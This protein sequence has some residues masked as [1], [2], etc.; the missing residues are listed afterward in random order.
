MTLP[1]FHVQQLM[2]PSASPPWPPEG[3]VALARKGK[4]DTEESGRFADE[5]DVNTPRESSRES[6]NNWLRVS[7]RIGVAFLKENEGLGEW[8]AAK[9]AMR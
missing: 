9:R 7:I 6:P 2:P 4:S 8:G 5:K 3:F 1:R